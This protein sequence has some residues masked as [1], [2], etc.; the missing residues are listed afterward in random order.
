VR[1]N[2]TKLQCWG[3]AGGK[4]RR[5]KKSSNT[6]GT[7]RDFYPREKGGKWVRDISSCLRGKGK[8]KESSE[9]GMQKTHGGGQSFKVLG[10]GRYL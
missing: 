6:S 9:T 7:E 1:K 2:M 8:K 10:G 3:K 4:Q 5:K